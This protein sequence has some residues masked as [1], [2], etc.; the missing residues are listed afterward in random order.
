MAKRSS[1][2]KKSEAKKTEVLAPVGNIQAFYAALESGANAI[3]CGL[4]QFNARGRATNFTHKQFLAMVALAHKSNVKVY[5]TLNTVIKNRELP[6][7]LD[8]LSFLEKSHCD[9]VIVQDWGVYYLIRNFFPKITI[10]ASTQMGIHN[11]NGANYAKIIGINRVVLARELTLNEI[12]AIKKNSRNE[13]EIFVHGALC[14]SFSGM[15]LFS[16]YLGAHG[17]NRGVCTQPCRRDF[18]TDDCSSHFFNLKDNQQ[19][20][21]VPELTSIGISSLKIEGRLKSADYVAKVTRSYRMAVDSPKQ[22]RAAEEL[23]ETDLAREKTGYFMQNDLSDAITEMTHTGLYIG[24]IQTITENG[25][26]IDAGIELKEGDTIRIAHPDDEQ[27]QTV[28]I[29]TLTELSEQR[30]LV[31]CELE[32]AYPGLDVYLARRKESSFSSRINEKNVPNIKL[33]LD[34]AIKNKMLQVSAL[35]ANAEQYYIRISDLSWLNDLKLSE[36]QSLILNLS[37]KEWKSFNPNSELIQ[38]YKSH[39][40][41]ELPKFIPEEHLDFFRSLS[42]KCAE[43]GIVNFSVSHLDQKKLLPRGSRFITNENVYAFNDFSL[44]MYR[45]E[46]AAASIMPFENDRENLIGYSDKSGI[47]PIYFIPELFFSRMPVKVK[48]DEKLRDNEGDKYHKIVRDGITRICPD[49]VTSLVQFYPKF[50]QMGYRQFLID[51][52]YTNFNAELLHE[53]FTAMEAG[54]KLPK[55]SLF[56]YKRGLR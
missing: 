49:T 12:K 13:L 30:Y 19:L 22:I 16:S 43:A 17:A 21:T 6:D 48:T 23:L 7:L 34:D 47:L 24:E 44:K 37:Q 50:K 26:M 55:T 11:S 3:Y 25:F 46:G 18:K 9:S 4:K 2:Y 40:L 8:T 5:A 35:K 38:K 39:I 42:K 33:R 31:P 51:I 56:N 45:E 54:T 20:A 52:S 41:I 29:N 27:A 32:N 15:C 28:T 36:S 53:I 1:Y 14:Y 10:H